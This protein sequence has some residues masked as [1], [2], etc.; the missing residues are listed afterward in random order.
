M[1]TDTLTSARRNLARLAEE[2]LAPR[3]VRSAE[4]FAKNLITSSI[5]HIAGLYSAP[6]TVDRLWERLDAEVE[7]AV[8]RVR[9]SKRGFPARSAE[10]G[11]AWFE[12]VG[13]RIEVAMCLYADRYLAAIR[14]HRA[15][16]RAYERGE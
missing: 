4:A 3:E 15:E 10:W 12:Y 13:D 9:H 11:A 8:D 14:K 7:G 1:T 2:E 16:L 5:T 6:V